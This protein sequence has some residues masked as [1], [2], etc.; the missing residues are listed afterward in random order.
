[1]HAAGRSLPRCPGARAGGRCARVWPERSR[2]ISGAGRPTR[3]GRKGPPRAITV[4]VGIWRASSRTTSFSSAFLA[5]SGSVR[6]T[7]PTGRSRAQGWGGSRRAARTTRPH[8]HAPVP[9]NGSHAE[10]PPVPAVKNPSAI[11]C[12]EI[13]SLLASGPPSRNTATDLAP[14]AAAVISRSLVG[15][16]SLTN[17]API[18]LHRHPA[19]R[20][21][22]P[23]SCS[24]PPCW[25]R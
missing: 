11:R 17:F 1:M 4:R 6:N 2:R 14:W 5:C 16:R 9:P 3:S 24:P 19:S 18:R 7:A 13:P 23:P 10:A 15:S 12:G 8:E 22:A 25:R 20:A 21:H